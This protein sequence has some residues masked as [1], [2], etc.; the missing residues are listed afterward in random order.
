ME[1]KKMFKSRRSYYDDYK[2]TASGEYIYAGPEYEFTS[3]SGKTRKRWMLETILL[4]VAAFAAV[5]VPGFLIVPGFNNAYVLLPYA[6][7]IL[8]T[9]YLLA[10]LI[11][12]ASAKDTVRAWEYDKS[13]KPLQAATVIAVL[14]TAAAAVSEAVYLIGNGA[15]GKVL[16]AVLFIVCE[17]VSAAISVLMA[18]SVKNTEWK[19]KS[20]DGV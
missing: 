19:K 7:G 9:G 17:V 20:S 10:I 3:K 13:V 6:A 5:I 14:V 8:V 2:K 1:R 11:R 12:L 18:L 4:S 16:G 15:D